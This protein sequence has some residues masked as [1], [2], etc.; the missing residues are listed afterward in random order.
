MR[1][2]VELLDAEG[3]EGLNMRALGARLGS[4]P[5]TVYWHVRNKDD[6]VLLATDHVWRELH[7]PDVEGI[8]W[9]A[10]ANAMAAD[11]YSMLTRHPWLVPAFAAYVLY[12]EGK[13]RH[14]DQ[15]LAVFEAADFAAAEA[16]QAAAA[17]FTYVL[18][19]AAG[20]AAS[21]A[22]ERRIRRGGAGAEKQVDEAM[23][24]AREIATRYP[25]LRSRLDSSA[26]EYAAAPDESFLFGLEALLDGLDERAAGNRDSR[27]LG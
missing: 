5:T 2:A 21:A 7:L 17:V 6:L 24:E 27:R 19:N 22:L 25:R 1:T 16:D 12:G 4:A 26:A 13:A 14:D 23:A 8:G 15:I 10:A 18:G 20:A 9:R 3:L 11:L